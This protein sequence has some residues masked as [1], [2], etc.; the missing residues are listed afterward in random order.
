MHQLMPRRVHFGRGGA[1]VGGL[2]PERA[3]PEDVLVIILDGVEHWSCSAVSL[4][5]YIED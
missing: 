1:F 2:V 4:C 3:V 5:M